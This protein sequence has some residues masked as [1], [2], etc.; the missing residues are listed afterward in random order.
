MTSKQ[1]RHWLLSSRAAQAA[2]VLPYLSLE[3]CK[4]DSSW[5]LSLISLLWTYTTSRRCRALSYF[6]IQTCESTSQ[7]QVSSKIVLAEKLTCISLD[8]LGNLC[9]GG[10][11]SGRIYLWEVRI[12][13]YP[14]FTHRTPWEHRLH[15]ASCSTLGTHITARL[16]FFVL[17]MTVR[18]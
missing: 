13:D 16:M 9:A 10:T 7:D 6:H 2:I 12:C 15:L 11:A 17:Q 18:L 8:R 5:P 3:I 4:E 1:G 14:E